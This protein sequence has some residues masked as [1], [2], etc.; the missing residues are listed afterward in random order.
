MAGSQV[1][2]FSFGMISGYYALHGP[3]KVPSG[4][5]CVKEDPLIWL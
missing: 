5:E 2:P 3:L 1:R 4:N